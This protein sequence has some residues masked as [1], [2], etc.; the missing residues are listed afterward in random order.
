LLQGIDECEM[1]RRRMGGGN[2]EQKYTI[3]SNRE[4]AERG[5]GIGL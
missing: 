5:G 3:G 2:D 4:R 1:T